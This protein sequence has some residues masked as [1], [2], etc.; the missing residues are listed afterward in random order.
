MA[1]AGFHYL[2]VG[3]YVRCYYC[4]GG[5]NNFA[6]EDLPLKKHV[7]H[8]PNCVYIK[9]LESI[10]QENM[11]LV[12][13]DLVT[14]AAYIKAFGDRR[15]RSESD[16]D[17]EE[18]EDLMDVDVEPVMADRNGQIKKEEDKISDVMTTVVIP[19]WV[20]LRPSWCTRA[21]IALS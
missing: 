6:P 10:G 5:L 18:E 16:N 8:Y 11:E 19:F 20:R 9:V 2:R 15:L 21:N 13:G 1:A 12:T 3:D 17:E 7:K 14:R 4:K